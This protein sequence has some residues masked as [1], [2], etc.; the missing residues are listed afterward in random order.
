[1]FSDMRHG[2]FSIFTEP[3][4]WLY[5][6][7]VEGRQHILSQHGRQTDM[8]FRKIQKRLAEMEGLVCNAF[9]GYRSVLFVCNCIDECACGFVVFPYQS[10][11]CYW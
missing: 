6:V 5:A 1:M 4:K 9:G 7:N 11:P 3:L 10:E 8:Y 2:Y